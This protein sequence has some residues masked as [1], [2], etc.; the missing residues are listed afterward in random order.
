MRDD[1]SNAIKEVLAKRVGFLCSN[2]GCRQPT[3]GPQED[4]TKVI[5]LG[6]AAHIAAASPEGPRYD[7]IMT[8]AERASGNNGLWLCQSCGKLVDNDPVRYP[9]KTLQQWKE[10]AEESAARVLEQRPSSDN[11]AG[12]ARLERLMPDLLAEMRQDL[13]NSPLCREFV[14]LEKGV[15]YWANGN[16][17]TYSFDDHSELESKVGILENEGLVQDITSKNVRRFRISERLAR[18]LG[19]P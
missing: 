11:Y 9:V 19:A 6:V 8:P 10:S 4:P 13:A 18:Y 16:E 17:F 15:Y 5:N 1:F 12:F 7:S 14:L 3:S 2:P